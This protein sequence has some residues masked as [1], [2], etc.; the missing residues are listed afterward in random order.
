VDIDIFGQVVL[1]GYRIGENPSRYFGSLAGNRNNPPQRISDLL[2]RGLSVV[3]PR[4]TLEP[5]HLIIVIAGLNDILYNHQPHLVANADFVATQQKQDFFYSATR[6]LWEIRDDLDPSGRSLV[7]WAG[8][9]RASNA[10]AAGNRYSAY[11]E[12]RVGKYDWPWWLAYECFVGRYMQEVAAF[13]PPPHPPPGVPPRNMYS[14]YW[15]CRLA[16]AKCTHLVRWV[17]QGVRGN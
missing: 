5:P 2:R 3:A 4:R 16:E 15:H 12:S 10:I 7:L 17:S 1:D 13:E 8:F 11:V 9:S 14:R 6:R